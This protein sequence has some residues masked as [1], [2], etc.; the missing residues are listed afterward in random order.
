MRL[1]HTTEFTKYQSEV[2]RCFVVSVVKLGQ[3]Y[4]NRALRTLCNGK[5]WTVECGKWNTVIL[6][7]FFTFY[8][9]CN[10]CYAFYDYQV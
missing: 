7:L 1:L 6:V 4:Y 10:S 3:V 5:Q 8:F 2:S 9:Q